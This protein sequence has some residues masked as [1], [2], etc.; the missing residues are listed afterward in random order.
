ME[1]KEQVLNI[2]D[3]FEAF[4]KVK[5]LGKRVP[6][7]EAIIAKDARCS[8]LYA[9]KVLNNERFELGENIIKTDPKSACRYATEVLKGRWT[10]DGWTQTKSLIMDTEYYA[11]YIQYALI[12]DKLGLSPDEIY[13]ILTH[14]QTVNVGKQ[15]YDDLVKSLFPRSTLLVDRW[16][17]YGNHVRQRKPR[18][19]KLEI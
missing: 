9:T 4:L 5:E 1:T 11:A 12:P 15:L 7:L 10:K 19:I 17:G 6:E 18:G 8:V 16:I 14:E 13:D 3:P 2:T